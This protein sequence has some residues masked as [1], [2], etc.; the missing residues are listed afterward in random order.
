MVLEEQ[1]MHFF[2]IYLSPV[3]FKS[4]S[5]Q[6]VS[7]FSG[8]ITCTG[9]SRNC[10]HQLPEEVS[11]DLWGAM[12]FLARRWL[13]GFPG[14]SDS[15][16]P[17]LM[18]RSWSTSNS[19][20]VWQKNKSKNKKY[21]SHKAEWITWQIC[22]VVLPLCLKHNCHEGFYTRRSFVLSSAPRL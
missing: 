9:P 12:V 6:T 22:D 18:S 5:L 16:K 8:I 20:N 3:G 17:Q 11:H 15:P 1:L 19:V 21:V 10:S 4:Q 2:S 13:T 14:S 7:R